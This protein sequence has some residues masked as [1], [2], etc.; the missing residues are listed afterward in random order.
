MRKIILI[1]VFVFSSLINDY[2]L[3]F[4]QN[5]WHI[6][7]Q[8]Q[9]MDQ[10]IFNSSKNGWIFSN[11]IF[12]KTTNSG[13]SWSAPILYNKP[14]SKAFFVD[15][16]NGFKIQTEGDYSYF[17]KTINGGV[18]WT[19]LGNELGFLANNM[20][21]LN[22]NTGWIVGGNVWYSPYGR[23]SKTTNGGQNWVTQISNIND[24][25][26]VAIQML[27]INRGFC[28][29]R[30]D[31]I[32]VT[33]N[34]GNTWNK[35]PSGAGQYLTDIK[36]INNNTGFILL[37]S[38]GILK[39]TNS[40][41]NW[42]PYNVS[43]S[44]QYSIYFVDSAYGWVTG[45]QSGIYKT[46]N[47]GVNWNPCNDIINQYKNVSLYFKDRNTGWVGNTGGDLIKTTNGGINW[48]YIYNPPKGN[49]YSVAFENSS[50]GIAVSDAGEI[51]KSLNGGY[52][53]SLI[54]LLPDA[55]SSIVNTNADEYFCVGGRRIFHTLNG[56]QNWVSDS[57]SN[58]ILLRVF[59][60]NSNTGWI[61]GQQGTL[62]KTTNG[63]LNW[64]N[65]QININNSLYSLYFINALTGFAGDGSSH[66]YKTTDG[67]FN[68]SITYTIYLTEPHVTT[69]IY[70][71][72]N[73]TGFFTANY[74]YSYPLPWGVEYRY[75]YITTNAGINWTNA[76]YSTMPG[77]DCIGKTFVSISFKDS[78]N[79]YVVSKAGELISTSTGGLSW[80]R[81]G[82][83]SPIGLL[84]V[85]CK[86]GSGWITGN[87]GLIMSTNDNSTGI[88]KIVTE[89][90]RNFNLHQNYPNP[91]NPVTKIKFEI[92]KYGFPTGT[93]GNDK[94]VLKVFDILGK[95]ITT[96]VNE[97]LQ[98][99]T[100][101]VIFDGTNLP[102]GV[103]FYQLRAGD[104]SET[105]KLILLK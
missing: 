75:I 33:D 19:Q 96:L 3:V 74:H 86:N 71:K 37:N 79:G 45:Y 52:N 12:H 46:T 59:F 2:S 81:N 41:Y 77:Q 10:I 28:I 22:T 82:N 67:G 43:N 58:I 68:W 101:E 62:F 16:I 78:I 31:T 63:G 32:L 17:Y 92:P 25:P 29:S 85:Y 26:I 61:L 47:Y 95:E 51:Y 73:T 34:S 103:Y 20:Y 13:D 9:T 7:T 24:K 1:V 40:G 53:W 98:P 65:L 8:A 44:D 42:I 48:H 100:Y 21:F 54:N 66:I 27:N 36:F 90:P 88:K 15:S 38:F 80:L 55:I 50:T 5:V 87:S 93:F 6:Q 35:I 97:K 49:V 39:T 89:I 18:S 105:K 70:F 4:A 76:Y 23:I 84:N 94:I 30:W 56:G 99:G 69:S 60:I 11:G 83:F 102:S 91:F 57:L 64:T 104:F 72:D 14:N